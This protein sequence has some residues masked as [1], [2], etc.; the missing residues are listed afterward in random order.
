MATY[1]YIYIHTYIYIHIHILYTHTQITDLFKFDHDLTSDVEPSMLGCLIWLDMAAIKNGKSVNVTFPPNQPWLALK[2]SLDFFDRHWNGFSDRTTGDFPAD[3]RLAA[4][5]SAGILDLKICRWIARPLGRWRWS[6]V[7][8]SFAIC[9]SLASYW[10]VSGNRWRMTR[11]DFWIYRKGIYRNI[12]T[13]NGDV[14]FLGSFFSANPICKDPVRDGMMVY[15]ND[16]P[17]S[18]K[19]VGLWLWVYHI[20]HLYGTI[21]NCRSGWSEWAW[22]NNWDLMSIPEE[23]SLAWGNSWQ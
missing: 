12:S 5:I 17:I 20:N 1:I 21:V 18:G 23:E 13:K 15:C 8:R 7:V 11:F 22:S 14:W 6:L 19:G 16:P 9:K 3:Q 10:S 4:S 2:S